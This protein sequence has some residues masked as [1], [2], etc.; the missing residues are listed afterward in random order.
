M[1]GRQ[2]GGKAEKTGSKISGGQA[3]EK[4]RKEGKKEKGKT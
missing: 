1:L 2:A 3:K 4:V